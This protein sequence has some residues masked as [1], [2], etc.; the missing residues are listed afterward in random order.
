MKIINFRGDL[1]DNSAKKEA[2]MYVCCSRAL[3]LVLA[4][5]VMFTGANETYAFVIGNEV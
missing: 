4:G 1:T 5:L 2:L 3:V